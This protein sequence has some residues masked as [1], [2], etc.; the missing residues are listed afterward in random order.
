MALTIISSSQ[1]FVLTALAFA[2]VGDF[3]ATMADSKPRVNS[4]EC[5]A[6][7]GEF[8][9]VCCTNGNGQQCGKISHCPFCLAVSW[10]TE[11]E[12][13]PGATHLLWD[14]GTE[15]RDVIKP[16][17]SM[18]AVASVLAATLLKGHLANGDSMG[19]LRKELSQYGWV[20]IEPADAAR[21]ANAGGISHCVPEMVSVGDTAHVRL[22]EDLGNPH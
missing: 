2:S 4:A 5:W 18:A 15:L 9:Q 12:K 17:M 13:A 6:R 21:M 16:T 19:K 11:L 8:G 1:L 20:T 10:T 22:R 7:M 14:I 3:S